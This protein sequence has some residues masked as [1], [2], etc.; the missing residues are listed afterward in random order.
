[1]KDVLGVPNRTRERILPVPVI[2]LPLGFVLERIIMAPHHS[3]RREDHR[4]ARKDR[5]PPRKAGPGSRPGKRAESGPGGPPAHRPVAGARPRPKS[6]RRPGSNPARPG[7][8]TPGL[9]QEATGRPERL[10]KILAHAGLGSRRDCE[11][12]ILQGRVTVDGQV[13]RELGTKVDAEAAVIAVDGEKIQLEK[14]VYYAVNKPKGYVST[15]SDPSGRP[16]VIDLLPEVPERVYSVGRLDEDSMGLMILTNDGELANRLAHPR[17]GVEKVYR[18]LVAGTPSREIVDKL[19]QGI[20]LSD[21]KARAKRARV[22]G[23]QGE[24]TILELVLAEGKKREIRRMLAKLGHKVMSLTR[25]AIGPVVLKGLPPGEH[26]P[27]SR[28]EVDLLR[29]VAAGIAVAPPRFL[30]QGGIGSRRPSHGPKRLE[31]KPK[32]SPGQTPPGS[33][34]GHVPGV[35]LEPN[36]VPREPAEGRAPRGRRPVEGEDRPHRERSLQAGRPGPARFQGKPVPGTTPSGKP[37][38][39][40]PSPGKLISG[41]PMPGRPV[42]DRPAGAGHGRP[43]APPASLPGRKPGPGAQPVPPPPRVPKAAT[44]EDSASDAKPRRRIIGLDPKV[45]ADAGLALSGRPSR[46]RPGIKRRPPRRA[47]GVKRSIEGEDER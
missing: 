43:K 25:V 33:A 46:K 18:A 16:R 17:Y 47:S 3:S 5:R 36:K 40:R 38:P 24:A 30:D 4:P 13:V 26:R 2:G 10:Q 21:G 20:W 29:K 42:Q 28:T 14:M 35:S 23:T 8:A 9:E 45:A 1:M 11:E 39:G 22:V 34:E 37:I 44:A 41:R 27:L 32:P 12:Y 6:A 7:Q 31:G 19:M 15:S